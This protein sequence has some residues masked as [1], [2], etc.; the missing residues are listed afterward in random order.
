V[1][2]FEQRAAPLRQRF[3]SFERRGR[4]MQKPCHAAKRRVFGH[5]ARAMAHREP[6]WLKANQ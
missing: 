4:Q 1:L 3:E 5:F 6:L 2:A